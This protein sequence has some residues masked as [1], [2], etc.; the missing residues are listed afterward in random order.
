[1]LWSNC[2]DRCDV[3]QFLDSITPLLVR[4]RKARRRLAPRF[5]VFDAI[6][7]E[8][9]EL[10]HSRFLACL[11]D[12]SGMHDQ[13]P[14]LLAS[15]LRLALGETVSDT[16]LASSRVVTEYHLGPNGRLD[17]VILLPDG[18]II[19]IENKIDASEGDNQIPRYQ[20]WLAERSPTAPGRQLLVFLTPEGRDP[21]AVDP[22]T[23]VPCVSLSYS[24]IA[25]WLRGC[26][27]SAPRLQVVLEMY[28]HLCE[29]IGGT[30]GW[31]RLPNS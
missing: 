17:I 5:N 15:F 22:K 27:E 23:G 25:N 3:E 26:S 7:G 29:R 8:R 21:V 30:A 2:M 4:S 14:E 31:T 20:A 24:S 9:G 12:P 13:G 18:R 11:L 6:G 19:G 28:S 1:M 16:V 10:M